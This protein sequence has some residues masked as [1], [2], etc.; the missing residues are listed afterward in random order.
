VFST[1]VTDLLVYR[2]RTKEEAKE[3]EKP[4]EM[5]VSRMKMGMDGDDWE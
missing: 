4:E 1:L 5:K 2:L 3:K